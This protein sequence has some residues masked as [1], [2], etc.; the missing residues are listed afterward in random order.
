MEHPPL[1]PEELEKIDATDAVGLADIQDLGPVE[2]AAWS[3]AGDDGAAPRV[4]EGD[5]PW[6]FHRSISLS[7]DQPLERLQDVS[8]GELDLFVDRHEQLPVLSRPLG[9]L[10]VI[11]QQVVEHFFG[12]SEVS[13]GCE[14]FYLGPSWCEEVGW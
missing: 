10:I 11:L 6:V 4:S 13:T 5:R 12:G 9:Y 3:F 1:L 8:E 14:I 7:V 2:F